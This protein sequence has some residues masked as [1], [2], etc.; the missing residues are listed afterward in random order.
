MDIKDLEARLADQQQEADNTISGLKNR[1]AELEAENADLIQ[2]LSL[3]EATVAGAR[4]AM[5]RDSHDKFD[6]ISGKLEVAEKKLSQSEESRK[7]LEEDSSI[8]IA[9]LQEDLESK[10]KQA[11]E[12][13]SKLEESRSSMS[14]NLLLRNELVEC[15]AKLARIT[16]VNDEKLLAQQTEHQKLLADLQEDRLALSEAR[17]EAS[18]LRQE[19][20][21]V[22]NESED[23]VNQW[24][25]EFLA[26]T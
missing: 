3:T 21:E 14:D 18:S 12:L 2:K 25:G 23:V 26:S 10:K 6:E 5:E 19:L 20:A 15:Q 9:T 1:R 24:T 17:D 11:L 16:E 8:T 4:E 22:R 7:K 13:E